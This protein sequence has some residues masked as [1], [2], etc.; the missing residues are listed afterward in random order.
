MRVWLVTIGEPL[1]TDE[2]HPRLLRSGLLAETLAARGHDVL[3][4]SSAFEHSA[5]MFRIE[6]EAVLTA[7]DRQR[8]VLLNGGGYSR[9]VSRAR[10]RDH[11][12]LAQ[13]FGARAS[14]FASPDIVMVSLPSIELAAA[15]VEYGERQAV[16]VVVDVR[17]LWPDVMV[18]LLP[19][20]ARPVG[21]LLLSGM[22]REVER[23]CTGATAITGSSR[24]FR[25]WGVRHAGRAPTS[26]DRVFPHGYPT[27]ELSAEARDR[28]AESLRARGVD[29]DATRTTATFLGTIGKQFDLAPVIE[30]A[31]LLAS[32]ARMQIV[33]AG[34]G[35]RLEQ[36]RRQASGLANV[37]FPGWIGAPEIRVLLECS[38]V[39]LVAYENRHH[40]IESTPNKF[41]EYLSAGLPLLIGLDRGEMLDFATQH[42][43]GVSYS[44]SSGRFASELRALAD[45]PERAHRMRAAAQGA[46]EKHF[47]A[48]AVYAAL[49]DYLEQMSVR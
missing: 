12:R 17:D 45:S 30:G 33:L 14:E 34:D 41:A 38:T 27:P 23:A 29:L 1:P 3:W 25:D 43:C 48:D 32:D 20:I 40:W 15:A 11:R 4:W 7:G 5:K 6:G 37:V 18:D 2:G 22:R 35:E 21:E 42:G 10:L 9:N 39:G 8:I 28:A 16:P 24:M 49:A 31:R 19:R 47:R 46:F 36:Y 26:L 44:F 13:R